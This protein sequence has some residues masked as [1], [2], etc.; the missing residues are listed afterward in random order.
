MSPV[1]ERNEAERELAQAV[2]RL[3]RG[4]RM[5]V[6]AEG[7]ARVAIAALLAVLAAAALSVIVGAGSATV[8][9]MRVLGYLL[10][11]AAAVKYLLVPALQRPDDAR[12]ALYVEERAPELRQTLLS[13]VHELRL[14]PEER[15]S[16]A[17]SARVMAQALAEV[18]RIEAGPGLERSRLSRAAALLAGVAAAGALLLAIGPAVL[19]DAARVLFIPWSEAAAAPVFAVTVSPGN[20][21]VPKGG[22]VELKAAL[23]GFA[24]LS[25][26]LVLKSDT[27]TE[28][29]RI[30]MLRDSAAAEFSSRLFDLTR[31]TEYY[32]EADG[33]RS[34]A[35]RLTVVDLPAVERIALELRFPAY[36]GLA[37]ERIE[38]GGDVAAVRGTTVT[39]R[40]TITKPVKSGTLR[41]D[42]KTAVPLRAD[43]AG[44][45]VGSFRV[46]R[47]GFYRVD[48]VAADGTPVPGTLQY[49]VEVLDDHGPAVRI[50][51]PGRDTKVTLVEEVAVAVRA[52]DDFGVEGLELHYQVNG[53]AEQKI[54]LSDS[55][56]GR[57]QEVRAAHTLFLEELG[58][59]PGDLVSYFATAK[60]GAGNHS[61]SDIYFLEVRPFG[62]DYKQAESGGGGGGGGEQ[63]PEGLSSRQRDIIAGTFNWLRDSARTA[64][65]DRRENITTL[66][67]SQGRLKTDVGGLVRRLVE[68]NVVSADTTFRVIHAALDTAGREMQAAEERLGLGDPQGA[69]PREQR[70]LQLVQRAEAAYREVQVQLGQQSGGGGGGAAQQS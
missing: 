31:D 59:K 22:A 38:K 63:S 53:G 33:I 11:A 40:A 65:R 14:S 4:W 52:S 62:R 57:T 51:Q 39:V 48:L 30:P 29:V 9:T 69:L 70:A 55:A 7:A 44:R 43:S 23:R 16:P 27:A 13:A 20:A 34:P 17:L 42:D 15:P 36:T 49:V 12:L 21:Q 24:A 25:A 54:A 47:N 1:A 46:T 61:S 3:R 56:T 18:Q 37:V 26:E 64:E 50:E 68:R 58:L 45:L 28:W 60:D 67:I 8:V 5:R 35:F 66:A 6:F 32:V 19:K 10:I 41:L 2:H